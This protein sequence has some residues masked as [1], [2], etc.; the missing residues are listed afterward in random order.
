MMKCSCGVVRR[1]ERELREHIALL[2]PRWPAQRCTQ[3]HYDPQ[4]EQDV[5]YWTAG[6][7]IPERVFKVK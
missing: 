2:T 5:A 1:N 7:D 6:K 3:E 4:N